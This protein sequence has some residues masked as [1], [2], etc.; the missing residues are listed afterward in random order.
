MYENTAL[1]SQDVHGK[2]CSFEVYMSAREKFD[3]LC[4]L[5]EFKYS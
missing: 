3:E 2:E 1:Y 4:F 5:I